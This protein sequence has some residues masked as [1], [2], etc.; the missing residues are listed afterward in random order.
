MNKNKPATDDYLRFRKRQERQGLIPVSRHQQQIQERKAITDE[1][2]SKFMHNLCRTM[3]HYQ[4]KKTTYYYVT[5]CSTGPIRGSV[6]LAMF[7]CTRCHEQ[8]YA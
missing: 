3:G 4:D 6:L 5:Q 8:V 7:E 2:N 1:R